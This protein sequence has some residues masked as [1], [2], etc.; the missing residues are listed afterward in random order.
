M[1]IAEI[2]FYF[3]FNINKLGVN[4]KRQIYITFITYKSRMIA[5]YKV[6][7]EHSLITWLQVTLSVMVV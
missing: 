3:I 1:D 6:Q 5:P 4:D 7:L 2:S